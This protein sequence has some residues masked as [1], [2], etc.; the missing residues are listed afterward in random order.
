[1]NSKASEAIT[2]KE[3]MQNTWK[4]LRKAAEN[5]AVTILGCKL[6]DEQLKRISRTL[7]GSLY[8]VELAGANE[9]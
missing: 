2:P 4:V 9:V 6:D 3:L 8:F 1:M 5:V 7:I